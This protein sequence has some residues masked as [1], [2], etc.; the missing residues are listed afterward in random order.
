MGQ[1]IKQNYFKTILSLNFRI[2]SL[3]KIYDL[4]FKICIEFSALWM[5]S[6]ISAGGRSNDPCAARIP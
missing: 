1:N 4:G 2:W 5:R 6:N 3:I